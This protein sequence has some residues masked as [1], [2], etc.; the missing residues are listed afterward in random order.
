MNTWRYRDVIT[1][2]IIHACSE[3]C[4]RFW[5]CSFLVKYDANITLLYST[6]F[7]LTASLRITFRTQWFADKTDSPTENLLC[8]VKYLDILKDSYRHENIVIVMTK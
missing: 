8:S 1:Y 2:V 4:V 7:P 5:N 3:F 6:T